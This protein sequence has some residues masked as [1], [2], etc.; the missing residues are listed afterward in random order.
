MTIAKLVLTI[1][2]AVLL[3]MLCVPSGIAAP[4]KVTI[5]VPSKSLALMPYYFGF[6]KGFFPTDIIEP[7]FIVMAPPTAIAALVSGDLD[8]STTTGAATSAIMRG[9][10]LRRVFYVQAEP[11][12][13]LIAQ[14]EFKSIKELAGKIIAVT[15]LTDAV[16]MSARI[17]LRGNGIDPSQTTLLATQ[18]VNNSV[19]AL[20][21]GK[22]NAT[23]VA[24]PYAEDLESKGF[25]RLGEARTY[26]P[27][28]FIG[29]VA[30]TE[31]LKKN[32]QKSLA[33]IT[34]LHR[35]LT[36]I[37]N[38][39]NRAEVVRY[40]STYHKIDLALAEKAFASQLLSY[41]KD[42]TKPRVAVEKEIEIYRE[43]LKIQKPF[44]PDDLEDM[45]LLRKVLG[46]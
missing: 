21:T 9:H 7:Q 38:P 11:S 23:L 25:R 17:M 28:S 4:A 26:A 2:I 19:Q 37:H 12:H 13:A 42:G 8:F 46:K 31:S 6:D 16:G 3:G 44:T 40:I 20:M 10:P 27:M 14:N 41:S 39:A 30:T 22:V 15:A 24:P 35:T 29:L 18:N 33:L 45:N 34:G 43:I 5:H 36:Y 1:W 32:P